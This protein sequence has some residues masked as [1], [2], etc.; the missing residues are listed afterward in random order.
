[1]GLD[2][3]S[4]NQL[5]LTPDMN[6]AELNSVNNIPSN[7]VK[8]IDGLANGQRVDPDKESEHENNAFLN[9]N[10]AADDDSQDEDEEMEVVKYDLSDSS[11]YCLKLDASENKIQIIE[12]KT[13]NVIQTFDADELMKLISFSSSSCG[14]I[15]N[16]KF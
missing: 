5:R 8:A 10:N 9:D 2:G 15:V 3:I 6:S 1:M 16:K 11:K 14:S 7:E 12:K 13:N 4:V